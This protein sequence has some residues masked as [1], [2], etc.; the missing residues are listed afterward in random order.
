L[1]KIDSLVTSNLEK[2]CFDSEST[3]KEDDNNNSDDIGG[4]IHSPNKNNKV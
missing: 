3:N 1:W 2:E 4:K